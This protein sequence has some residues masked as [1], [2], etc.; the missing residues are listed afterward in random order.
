MGPVGT[1]AT[2][3]SLMEELEVIACLHLM[4]A[5]SWLSEMFVPSWVTSQKTKRLLSH[6]LDV[7]DVFMSV[8]VLLHAS[9]VYVCL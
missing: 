5:E 4:D 7:W 2:L 3:A 9:E 6:S 1:A 8:Y